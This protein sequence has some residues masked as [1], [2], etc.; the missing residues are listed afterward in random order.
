MWRVER[1]PG[2]HRRLTP[3]A[4]EVF[5]NCKIAICVNCRSKS[6][7]QE[8]SLLESLECASSIPVEC[9]EGFGFPRAAA[10][11]RLHPRARDPKST[12]QELRG[13]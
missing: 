6:G 1:T 8:W 7:V 2:P 10:A 13:G 11:R 4:G 9:R 3:G 12:K 5:M